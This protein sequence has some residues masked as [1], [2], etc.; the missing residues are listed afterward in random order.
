NYTTHVRQIM[1]T[2]FRSDPAE[3]RT[4][5]ELRLAAE[6]VLRER[7]ESGMPYVFCAPTST[8]SGADDDIVLWGPGKQHDWELELAIVIGRHASNVPVA[9][10]MDYVAGYTICNDISTRDLI[11][12]PGFPMTDL[13]M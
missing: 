8:L 2:A 1:L 9:R 12:R 13:L 5:D 7:T 3:R 6:E 10:A 4:D 11:E